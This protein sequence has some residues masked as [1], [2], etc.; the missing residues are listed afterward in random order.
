[1]TQNSILLYFLSGGSVAAVA[2]ARKMADNMG[3]R[4]R[5]SVFRIETEGVPT[6]R[7]KTTETNSVLESLSPILNSMRVF[8]LYFTRNKPANCEAATGQNRQLV[9]SSVLP[10]RIKGGPGPRP[11]T[12]RGLPTKPT[13]F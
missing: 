1:M 12:N 2:T 9:R 6:V 4:L 8:G 10:G 13:I 3:V 11:A 5:S 7:E